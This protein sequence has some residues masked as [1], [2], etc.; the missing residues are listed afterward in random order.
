MNAAIKTGTKRRSPVVLL[1]L[2]AALVAG[3]RMTAMPQSIAE[4]VKVLPE[5]V[6][7]WN[8]VEPPGSY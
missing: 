6:D 7:R 8:R 2:V 4:F 3:T 5:K 1:G